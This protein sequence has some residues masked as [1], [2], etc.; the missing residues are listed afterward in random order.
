MLRQ[1]KWQGDERAKVMRAGREQAG[2]ELKLVQSI[3]EIG[4]A[5]WDACA[6]TDNPFLSYDFLHV[7]EEA[8]TVTAR[9]G[10][11]PQHVVITDDSKAVLAAVPLYLKGH[12]QGE[13]VF[14]HGWAHAFER[15]GG[16]YYPK[17]ISA[18]PF[19]PVSGPRLLIHPDQNRSH[20]RDLL[21]AG[22]QE[23]VSA[24]DVSSLHLNFLPE[25]DWHALGDHGFLQRLGL[26]YHW[27]NH[28]YQGFD[29]FL[30][31]LA[32]RKRKAI[33]KERREVSELDITIRQATGDDIRP[34][35][36]DVFY[37]F[38]IDTSDRKWGSA[39]L[40]REFFQLLGER[41]ADQVLL[42]IAE[43]DGRPV[44]GALNLIGSDTLF[45]R[46]WGCIAD[47]KFLH[48]E[49]CYYQA[50]DFAIARGLKRVE[51]GAQGPHK[52]QRGYVPTY[53]HSAHFIPH[54]GFHQAV[55]SFLAAE[56]R[57]MAAEK[58]YIED[59]LPF[60]QVDR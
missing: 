8:G 28:G 43:Q 60:R 29:D 27:H 15:A 18:V 5:A 7:L 42:V 57:E 36:W 14:D 39:Y 33:R 52:I 34:S 1:F 23:A 12:S 37:Q 47:F 9:T 55:E 50:I 10:W 32:S 41:M 51:A 53:T 6:G 58:G 48:F 30:A 22:L 59:N 21:V 46:N 56:R 26:Q 20:V 17:L 35:D 54:Q 45:G 3:A 31:D 40:N 16:Q 49:I 44:A 25:E 4:K 38:Y 2:A 19:T 24:H 13:Y 11:L